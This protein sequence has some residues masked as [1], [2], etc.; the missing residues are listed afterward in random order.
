MF[1]FELRLISDDLPSDLSNKRQPK[2][3]KKAP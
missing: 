3:E 2:C 1:I